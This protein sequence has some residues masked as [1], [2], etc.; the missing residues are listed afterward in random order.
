[1]IMIQTANLN[2]T[3]KKTKKKVRHQNIKKPT[4][5]RKRKLMIKIMIMKNRLILILTERYMSWNCF[6]REGIACNN[7]N[8]NFRN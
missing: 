1:M 7:N 3:S 5:K 8:C 6:N 2:K 4:G